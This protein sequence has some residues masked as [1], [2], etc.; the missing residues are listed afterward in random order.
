MKIGINATCLNDRPSGAK[1][2]FI[3]IYSSLFRQLNEAEFIIYEPSDC[4]VT[5]WFTGQ[6]NI[7]AIATPIPS[8][9]RFAKISSNF[10]YW[11]NA[12]KQENFDIFESMHLPMVRYP[13]GS[14]ILTIHDLRGLDIS[15][16]YFS[17]IIYAKV[18][19][20]SLLQADHVITVSEAMRSEITNF[21]PHKSISVIYNGLNFNSFNSVSSIANKNF[22]VKYL[23]PSGYLLAI[24]HLESRKNY[25]RL[26]SSLANLSKRGID[27]PLV[28]IGND[29]G[30]ESKL[31]EHINRLG[32]KHRVF[33][34]KGLSD[35]EVKCA[36][37]LSELVIFPSLYEGFGIP[38]L[39]AM[40]SGKP[41]VLSDIPVFKEITQNKCIYFSPNNIDSMSD[42]I[43]LGL[44][45]SDIRDIIIKYGYSRVQ[46]FDFD[47]LA[48]SLA[49][50]YIDL[51]I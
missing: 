13:N 1:Q 39:E 19:R 5:R 17:K 26:I 8:L 42:A 3:G 14:N 21:F 47:V 20:A 31:I 50:R 44:I 22:L 24:G 32:L 27:A 30:E 4:N 38:I 41:M 6:H 12:L 34:L 18:L 33:I 23:L 29:S 2:R 35:L 10:R 15:N 37:A 45:S 7:R 9:G 36:Y 46:D 25:H 11:G 16:N 40:A 49:N 28:I 43:E 48:K 51:S